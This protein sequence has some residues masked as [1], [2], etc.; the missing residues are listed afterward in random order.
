MAYLRIQRFKLTRSHK[1]EN[2]DQCKSNV[3]WAILVLHVNI[4]MTPSFGVPQ[5]TRYNDVI[6]H[7][8]TRQAS[9]GR[10]HVC[11]TR[12]FS[13]FTSNATVLVTLSPPSSAASKRTRSPVHFAGVRYCMPGPWSADCDDFE[14]GCQFTH[15]TMCAFPANGSQLLTCT[16]SI[17]IHQHI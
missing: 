11:N 13:T 2:K 17:P 16:Q 1:L 5:S 3:S 7:T 8:Q 4:I 12:N 14:S 10:Q 6:S 9:A 15:F